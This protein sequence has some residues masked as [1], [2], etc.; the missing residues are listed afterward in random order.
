MGSSNEKLSWWTKIG[1]GMGDIYGGGSG[2]IISFYYLIF[3]TDVVR[4]PP[5]LAGTVILISKLYDSIT[6]PF[7]GLLADRTRTKMGR[8][9]P[10]LLIG[11]PLVFLSFFALFYPFNMASEVSRFW[12]VMLSYLFFST[13]VS[14]VMLNY[15]ALHAEITLDY[16]ERSSLSSIRIFFSTVASIVAALV[17]LEIV[18]AF[19][20]IHTGYIVMGL[21]F[22]AF[23]ALPYIATIASV[24]ERHEFQRPPEAFNW[25]RAFLDPFKNRTFVYTLAMYLFAFVAIDTVSTIVAYFVKY[26]LQ[27]SGEVSFV[28]GTL[29]VAQVISLP[30]YLAISKRTSKIRG[31]IIGL[32][33]WAAAMIF[34]FLLSPS[35]ASLWVYVFAS[36]VGLGTGGIVVMIYAIFPD[37]PD[38]DE[39]HSGERREAIYSALVTFIRKF[40]SAL[41]IFAVSNVIGWAGY[42]PPVQQTLNGAT[43]L[44]EQPQSSSF[45]LVLRLI[46]MLLPIALLV[47]ALIFAV[48]FPLTPQ[49]HQRLNLLLARQRAGEP[50]DEVEKQELTKVLLG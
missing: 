15:N 3:L 32:G 22:G 42:V 21:A 44:I 39:L 5:A 23:F 46:F 17:P 9:R 8:R 2:V 10:Y 50:V 24:K 25:R 41:A 26:Y 6:D 35:N 34:S 36:V 27:R 28:N 20:D 4:I 1:Y 7:E 16:N 31:Y 48:R 37:I 11:I 29:L 30:F 12:A 14:I 38:V 13:V 40:S 33:I 47:F 18:K 49:L 19:P 43:Q 45:L